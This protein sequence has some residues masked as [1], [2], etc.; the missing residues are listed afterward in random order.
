MS[1]AFPLP[2]PNGQ[3]EAPKPSVS[4]PE[5][6]G[7]PCFG[8]QTPVVQDVQSGS[9]ASS[10]NILGVEATW[11]EE[12]PYVFDLVQ[13]AWLWC[14]WFYLYKQW[15][16]F[17]VS[18]IP[19]LTVWLALPSNCP[20][21]GFP[22]PFSCVSSPHRPHP[23]LIPS[24]PHAGSKKTASVYHI[25]IQSCLAA[26]LFFF[27]ALFF[28]CIV[29]FL[30]FFFGYRNLPL[31]RLYFILSVTRSISYLQSSIVWTD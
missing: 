13:S 28:C 20:Q 27:L 16:Q 1:F 12:Q 8:Q 26:R 21:S 17:E 9:P 10:S 24:S 23:G 30:S 31:L 22:S 2:L 3:R 7:R 19:E 25:N 6:L 11:S 18:T 29:C 14:S 5:L 4:D 15:G